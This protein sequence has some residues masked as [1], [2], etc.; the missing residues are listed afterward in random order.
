MVTKGSW[1]EIYERELATHHIY[2]SEEKK[3]NIWLAEM[4]SGADAKMIVTAV[5]ACKAINPENPQAAAEAYED[6]FKALEGVIAER[7]ACHEL[8]SAYIPPHIRAVYSAIDKAL[9]K[10]ERKEGE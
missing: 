5:N 1:D 7:M 8:E 3:S 10:A 2:A 4:E 6:V 9:A